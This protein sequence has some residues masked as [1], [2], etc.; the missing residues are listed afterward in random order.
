MSKFRNGLAKVGRVYHFKFRY[1]G[2]DYHGS[3]GCEHRSTAESYLRKTREE[4]ALRHLGIRPASE[5]P[6]LASVAREWHKAQVLRKGER[7]THARNVLGHVD[8][9][10]APLADLRVSEI[11]RAMAQ[12]VADDYLAVAG[13]TP[14]GANVVL[15]SLSLLLGFAVEREYLQVRPFKVRMLDVQE[16]PKPYVPAE[17]LAEFFE[18]MRVQGAPLRAIRLALLMVG[19]GL[20][21]SEARH[22]RIEYTDLVGRTHTP[23]D[24]E[25]G[26]KGGEAKPVPIFAWLVPELAEMIGDRKDGLI[27]PGRFP[28]RPCKRAYTL[29][30]VKTAAV[31]MG[32]PDLTPHDLRATFATLLSLEGAQ[33]KAIQD[34]LRHKDGRTTQRYIRP[35]VESL[36]EAGDKVGAKAGFSEPNGAMVANLKTIKPQ[37]KKRKAVS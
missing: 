17:R 24:P 7:S 18:T 31:A 4:A 30:Y 22:A 6:T 11:T 33:A 15:R 12:Q 27:V 14:G 10:L 26:T 2:K 20:R 1:K 5:A 16:V 35:V 23:F 37:R 28:S 29:D 34:A 25:I 8:T 32:I 9:H 36:R 19:L 21:E 3:T 13:N